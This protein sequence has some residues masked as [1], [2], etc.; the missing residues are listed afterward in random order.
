MIEQG[1]WCLRSEDATL[2][3]N[4]QMIEVLRQQRTV[5]S[6]S[7]TLPTISAYQSTVDPHADIIA[8]AREAA[9]SYLTERIDSWLG[10]TRLDDQLCAS[11]ARFL[12]GEA[13][14]VADLVN[15]TMNDTVSS[16]LE[17][18]L[19]AAGMRGDPTGVLA[20]ITANLVLE[21]FS[22]PIEEVRK[23]IEIVGLFISV[24]ALQPSLAIACAKALLH[25][26]ITTV[27]NDA[28]S[29]LIDAVPAV[30]R[31]AAE[32]AHR[33]ASGALAVERLRKIQES[34]STPDNDPREILLGAN[35]PGIPRAVYDP[36]EIPPAIDGLSSTF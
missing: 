33:A 8:R 13:A 19:N 26:E 23:T 25:E 4:A 2:A 35:E 30:S 36:G 6:T 7:R 31:S 29:S 1:W 11:S 18:T 5:T 14:Q 32:D 17:N 27:I 34:H 9:S 12:P 21:P 3:T 15:S 16:A 28:I 10:G 20:G 24:V 22:E